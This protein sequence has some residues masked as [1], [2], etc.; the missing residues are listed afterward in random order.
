MTTPVLRRVVRRETH[1]PRTTAMIIAV[2]LVILAL[3]Y[4]GTEIVLSLLGRPALLLGPGAA[5]GAVVG[6]PTAVPQGISIAAGVVIGILGLVLIVLALKPG[7][8]PRH[9]L[10]VGDRAVV[11]DNG[12]IA[13]AVAQR[14]SD[15]TGF[16][17][18]QVRVGVSHRTV[19]VLI[20]PAFGVTVDEEQVRAVA[21]A[22]VESYRLTPSV[23]TK[24]RVQRPKKSE[25]P[26]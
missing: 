7:R 2:V 16:S 12:V 21:A 10:T 4:V 5:L 9:A 18:D 3:A 25:D 1:S 22:E 15:E 6:L 13:S 26:R 14:V 19:D 11:A 20:D 17:R 23:T 8:L 24:V